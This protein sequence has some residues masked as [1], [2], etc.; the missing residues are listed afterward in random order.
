MAVAG[1]QLNPVTTGWVYAVDDSRSHR[2]AS[3]NKTDGSVVGPDKQATCNGFPVHPNP[4]G[5]N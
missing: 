3:P 5:L 1:R 2:E 4:D